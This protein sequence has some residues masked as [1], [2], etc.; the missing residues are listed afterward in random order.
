MSDIV[1][2]IRWT[3]E[4]DEKFIEDFLYLQSEVFHCG[5]RDE[6]RCQFEEN[7]YGKSIVVVVYY[8]DR[9][10]AARGLWRNDIEGR[11]AYQP[12]GTCVLPICRGKGIFKEMTMR[13]IAQLS[14]QA[15]IYNFPNYNSFPGYIKMGWKL[16]CD[17]RARLY[18]SYSEY[19][20]EHPIKVDEKYVNWWLLGKN[21]LYTKKGN[22]YFLVQ[23][24]R[25]PLCYYIFAEVDQTSA[26]K[27]PKLGLGILFY[28][29]TKTTWYNNKLGPS[30][31][32]CKNCE[33]N[34]IPTWKID[35]I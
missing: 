16:Q 31:V 26:L 28:K 3:D 18:T 6:F 1:Y 5:S 25:R 9:P 10:V 14:P 30:H 34:Y 15:I 22:H 2:D 29:S 19:N 7:I 24:D 33:L 21:L 4:L 23:K 20:K 27:F 12:G 8:E 17:Y 35:A 11:E 32:V 13:A